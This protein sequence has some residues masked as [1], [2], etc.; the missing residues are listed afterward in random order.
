[1]TFSI[2]AF[3]PE[4]G[5]LG[6]AVS[7]A[8]P[9]VGNRV[10]F[11]RFGV[12]AAATQAQSNPLLGLRALDLHFD[13]QVTGDD[14]TE[15]AREAWA[16]A[17]DDEEAFARRLGDQLTLAPR[18]RIWRVMV[19]PEVAFQSHTLASNFSRPRSCRDSPT[20]CSCRSTTICVAIPAWSVPGTH[21]VL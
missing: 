4:T 8:R 1:M 19:A 9:A 3:L 18:R 20:S 6:V 14:Y 5:E 11:V 15:G 16:S 2:V 13:G 10:P 7:T 17:A 12:G 21:K